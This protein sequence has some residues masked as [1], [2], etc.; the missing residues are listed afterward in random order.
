MMR[1][2]R[3]ARRTLSSA[4]ARTAVAAR[5]APARVRPRPFGAVACGVR[6]GDRSGGDSFALRGAAAAMSAALLSLSVA[7]CDGEKRELRGLYPE[8]EPYKTGYIS[9]RDGKHRLYYEECGNPDGKP[10]LFLHG[11]PAAGLDPLYRRFFD[12]SFYRIILIDQRGAGKSMPSASLENNDTWHLVEDLELLREVCGVDRWHTVL[13]GSWGSTLGLAYAQSHPSRVASMVLRGIFLFDKEDMHWLFEHGASEH[14]P[15]RWERFT[16][17]VPSWERGSMLGAYYRRLTSPNRQVQLEAARRFVEWEMSIS[18]LRP[19]F[20]RIDAALEDP[21][22]FLPFARAECHYFVN[23]GWLR[24][25]QLLD[26]CTKI[27]SLPVA[28]VHGRYDIVCRPRM[29]WE[30]HERLPNSTIDF[31]WDSGHS[32]MEPNTVDAIIRATDRF[33]NLPAQ[34]A[35]SP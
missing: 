19:D 6:A 7:R 21:V 13:G 3:S 17:I 28:I 16:S 15:D 11:G 27:R 25:H 8:I 9:T 18:S 10:C 26:D 22:F 20:R 2:A 30:L 14:F 4:Q 31:T 32:T 34:A 35:R 23:G 24:P 33:R 29:A 5:Q 1:I 12:P